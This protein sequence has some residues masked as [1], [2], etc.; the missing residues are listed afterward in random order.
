MPRNASFWQVGL[1]DVVLLEYP[2][3]SHDF[4]NLI[5]YD[6]TLWNPIAF[7]YIIIIM[8]QERY[9]EDIKQNLISPQSINYDNFLGDF[10]R[11][12]VKT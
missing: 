10:C 8:P 7:T 3:K 11:N 2:D 6:V 4:T 5:F 1:L 9:E 12:G